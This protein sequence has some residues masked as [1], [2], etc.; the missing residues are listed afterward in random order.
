MCERMSLIYHSLPSETQILHIYA[1]TSI[2]Y[3]PLEKLQLDS[4]KIKQL[5]INSFQQ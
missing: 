3:F 1:L 2:L 4:Y 5:I